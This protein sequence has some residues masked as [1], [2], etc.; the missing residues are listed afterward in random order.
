MK[1]LL[2]HFKYLLHLL[3]QRKKLL[4]A[5]CSLGIIYSTDIGTTWN[6]MD[7]SGLFHSRF[8]LLT[9]DPKKLEHEGVF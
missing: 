1:P 8:S 9:V 2:N 3:F 4:L 6:K 7:T 5:T